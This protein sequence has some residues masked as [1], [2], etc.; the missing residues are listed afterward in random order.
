MQL[1]CGHSSNSIIN[2]VHRLQ[3]A[4]TH[5][6]ITA[7]VGYLCVTL[8]LSLPAVA[9][10]ANDESYGK[11]QDVLCFAEDNVY[12]EGHYRIKGIDLVTLSTWKKPLRLGW[13]FQ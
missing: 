5:D 2:V 7:N 10:L 3:V 4:S 8:Y 9:D 13:L 1:S 11:P 12:V 6:Q